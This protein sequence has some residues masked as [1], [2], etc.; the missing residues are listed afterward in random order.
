MTQ[1]PWHQ[2]LAYWTNRNYTTDTRTITFILS[3]H[4]MTKENGAFKFV[5]GTGRYKKL[6]EHEY[7]NSTSQYLN[8]SIDHFNERVKYIEV[9]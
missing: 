9:I 3:F 7:L 6:R 2:D 5:P 4:N 1:I 8:A